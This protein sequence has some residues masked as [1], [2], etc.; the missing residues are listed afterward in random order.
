[1]NRLPWMKHTP[2][3]AFVVF[4]PI[5]LVFVSLN[6]QG[7][8]RNPIWTFCLIYI[9]LWWFQ[10]DRS[11]RGIQLP[12]DAGFIMAALWPIVLPLYLFKSRG[13]KAFRILFFVLGVFIM[14]FLLALSIFFVIGRP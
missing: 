1:M 6:P 14:S 7:Y 12:F 2:I 10:S 4:L 3:I 9:I 8:G 5:C 11:D 13:V